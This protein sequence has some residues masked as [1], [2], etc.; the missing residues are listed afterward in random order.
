MKPERIHS[1]ES[2]R[3]KLKWD[4]PTD[5]PRQRESDTAEGFLPLW[6]KSHQTEVE[7]SRGI[8][9]GASNPA[10]QTETDRRD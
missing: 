2:V 9:V 4:S 7:V 3:G 10:P 5:S 6:T 8:V 1:H